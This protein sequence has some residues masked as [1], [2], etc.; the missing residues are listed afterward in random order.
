[1]SI[2]NDCKKKVKELE[3]DRL[4]TDLMYNPEWSIEFDDYYHEGTVLANDNE[5]EL[6][7]M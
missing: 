5:E 1:M 6:L 3:M 4:V 7:A 2:M